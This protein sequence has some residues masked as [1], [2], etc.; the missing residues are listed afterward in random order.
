MWFYIC[1]ILTMFIL[2]LIAK[3]IYYLILGIGAVTLLIFW[4]PAGILLGVLFAISAIKE[5]G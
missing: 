3:P 1:L 2:Y 5:M 4:T